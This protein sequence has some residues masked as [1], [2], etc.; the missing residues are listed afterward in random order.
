MVVGGHGGRTIGALAYW[1]YE[2]IAHFLGTI[3]AIR[4]PVEVDEDQGTVDLEEVVRQVVIDLELV[5]PVFQL[6]GMN[7]ARRLRH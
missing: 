3:R 7:L 5:L 4:R 2:S 1:T 6:F